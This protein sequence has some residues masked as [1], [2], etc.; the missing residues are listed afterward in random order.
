M[1]T[2]TSYIVI[3][4]PKTVRADRGTENAKI[5]FIQPFLRYQSTNGIDLVA[6]IL[7]GMVALYS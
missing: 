6:K 5:A 1:L 2:N 7:F 4:C 3:G